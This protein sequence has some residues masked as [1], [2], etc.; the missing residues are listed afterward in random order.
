M[1]NWNRVVRCYRRLFYIALP[2]QKNAPT[3]TFSNWQQPDRTTAKRVVLAAWLPLI[4]GSGTVTRLPEGGRRQSEPGGRDLPG[5]TFPLEFGGA[6][7]G[8]GR[9]VSAG[10]AAPSCRT[11]RR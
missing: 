9:V 10:M 5:Y 4:P 8:S 7:A 2:E 1:K 3:S 11:Q 6:L